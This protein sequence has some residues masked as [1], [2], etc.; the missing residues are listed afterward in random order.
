MKDLIVIGSGAMGLAAAYEASKQGKKVI[1]LEGSSIPGGMAAHL[2]FQ[3]YLLKDFII[4]FA[5]QMLIL[6]TF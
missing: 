1:V 6:S 4:L 2:H 3:T 5:K